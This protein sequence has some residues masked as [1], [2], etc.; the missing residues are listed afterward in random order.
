MTPP[1]NANQSIIGSPES[2]IPLTPSERRLI[3]SAAR[4]RLTFFS[5]IVILGAT[6]HIWH[7]HFERFTANRFFLAYNIVAWAGLVFGAFYSASCQ[8]RLHRLLQRFTRLDARNT[9]DRNA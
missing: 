1:D 9:N 2:P 5:A 3:R 6:V 7:K 4:F 8:H